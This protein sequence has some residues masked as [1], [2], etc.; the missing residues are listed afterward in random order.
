MAQHEAI[1]NYEYEQSK[2]TR[3]F[4]NTK[5]PLECGLHRSFVPLVY[6]SIPECLN[7]V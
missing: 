7:S 5:S 4:F 6:W 1:C 3:Y 2:D